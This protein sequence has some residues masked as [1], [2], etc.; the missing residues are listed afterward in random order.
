MHDR[1]HYIS[2]RIHLYRT[3]HGLL[4]EHRQ[5]NHSMKNG[6]NYN[7]PPETLQNRREVTD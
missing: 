1:I 2:Q 3:Y 6:I 5:K 4:R 7:S